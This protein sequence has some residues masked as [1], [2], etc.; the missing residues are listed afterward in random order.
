MSLQLTDDSRLRHLLTVDGL[1]R[2]LIEE[3]L[4]VADSMRSVAL[5][6]NKKLPLLRGRT[7]INLFFE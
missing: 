2:K 6:G 4:D 5:R 3:L 1:P 7:I